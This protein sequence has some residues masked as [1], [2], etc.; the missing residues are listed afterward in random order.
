[1]KNYKLHLI[2]HFEAEGNDEGR[3]IGNTAHHILESSKDR[4]EEIKDDCVYPPCEVLYTAPAVRC[5]ETA[6]LIYP[7]F[8][9]IICDSMR[10]LDFGD[11]EGKTIEELQDREDYR[12]WVLDAMNNPPPDGE[13]TMEFLARLYQGLDLI[14]KDMCKKNVSEAVL[15]TH[16]GV[17]M[18]L[19]SAFGLPRE[20]IG[21]WLSK[22]GEGYTILL[23]PQMWLRDRLFEIYAKVPFD[24]E[25]LFENWN[26]ERYHGLTDQEI[27]DYDEF[28]DDL[29]NLED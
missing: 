26:E 2:R 9:P 20:P 5:I 6:Q 7:D 24:K 8:E 27:F 11:F 12:A 19:L 14:F 25:S 16:G 23:N 1:M 4:L 15:V 13:G 3:Y 17:I 22:S 10:E 21:K 18:S 29:D 28:E